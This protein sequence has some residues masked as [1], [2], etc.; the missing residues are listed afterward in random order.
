MKNPLHLTAE[1]LQEQ[2]R[3]SFFPCSVPTH[4][5]KSSLL[6]DPSCSGASKNSGCRLLAGFTVALG[7]VCDNHVCVSA[8]QHN[9]EA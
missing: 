1:I 9:R 6:S 8:T 7:K 2:E 5:V 4:V 3:G